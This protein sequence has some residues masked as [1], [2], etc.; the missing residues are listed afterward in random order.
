[1]AG[2]PA[3]PQLGAAVFLTDTGLETE[4]IFRA[5]LGGTAGVRRRRPG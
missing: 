4:L 1:M 3:L 2:G 5:G